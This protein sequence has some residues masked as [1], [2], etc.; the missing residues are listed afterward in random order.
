MPSMKPLIRATTPLSMLSTF[1]IRLL[2]SWKARSP[3]AAGSRPQIFDL[4]P[5]VSRLGE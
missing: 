5:E 2:A 4:H 1:S 3:I